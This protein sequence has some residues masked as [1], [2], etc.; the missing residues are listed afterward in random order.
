MLLLRERMKGPNFE[1]T[2]SKLKVPVHTTKEESII[3]E[4]KKVVAS[5][6]EAISLHKYHVPQHQGCNLPF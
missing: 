6:G 4:R 3:C 1:S 5:N 2:G